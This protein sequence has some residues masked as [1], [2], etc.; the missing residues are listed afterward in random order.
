MD[1]VGRPDHDRRLLRLDR[2]PLTLDAHRAATRVEVQC[3]VVV[4]IASTE[5]WAR[6][7]SWRVV[8]RA[9]RKRSE[10][11]WFAVGRDHPHVFGGDLR[12]RAATVKSARSAEVGRVDGEIGRFIRASD[13]RRIASEILTEPNFEDL[14]AARRDGNLPRRAAAR[15]HD[16]R[17]ERGAA[18]DISKR[19]IDAAFDI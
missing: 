7:A 12:R 4:R 16:D 10:R 9:H 2:G 5:G 8:L 15:Q 18:A 3:C 11:L 19:K 14:H 17:F 13:A 6:R 1:E